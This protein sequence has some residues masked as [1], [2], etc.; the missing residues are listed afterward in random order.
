MAGSRQYLVQ[1]E[2]RQKKTTSLYQ[3]DTRKKQWYDQLYKAALRILWYS[4]LSRKLLEL[5]KGRDA[6][7]WAGG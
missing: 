3:L 5:V 2:Q 1:S 4:E 7:E 6:K